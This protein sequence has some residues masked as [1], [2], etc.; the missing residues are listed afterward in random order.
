[1]YLRTKVG[2]FHCSAG[3]RVGTQN[4]R[5]AGGNAEMP[6]AIIELGM[7]RATKLNP[8]PPA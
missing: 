4:L 7:A 8:R 3:R 5:Q 2:I 6:N 1:M